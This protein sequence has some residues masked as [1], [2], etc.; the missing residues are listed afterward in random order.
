MPF[1]IF[2]FFHRHRFKLSQSSKDSENNVVFKNSYGIQKKGIY[3][4]WNNIRYRN[5]HC[6]NDNLK[7]Q[8]KVCP[9]NRDTYFYHIVAGVLQRHILAQHLFIIYLDCALR[10]SIELL[11]ESGFTLKR[12]KSRRYSAQTITD[13][14]YADDIPHLANSATLTEFLLQSL[15]QAACGIGLYV[16]AERLDW[17]ALLFWNVNP[18]RSVLVV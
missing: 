1:W 4:F 8:V 9:P 17:L 14:D 10:T 2:F 12:A 11:K 5:S 13:A 3:I 7:K 6:H 16:N 18:F 15:Q